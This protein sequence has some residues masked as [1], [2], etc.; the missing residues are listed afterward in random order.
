MGSPG[1]PSRSAITCQSLCL[2]LLVALRCFTDTIGMIIKGIVVS[3]K[4]CG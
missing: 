1:L 4:S 2:R 3:A